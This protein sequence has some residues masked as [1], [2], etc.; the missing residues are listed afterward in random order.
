LRMAEEDLRG[1]QEQ[2]KAISLPEQTAAAIEAAAKVIG[3]MQTLEVQKDVMLATMKPTNPK[4]LQLQAQIEA[5]QKQL[6]RMAFGSDETRPGSTGEESNSQ[7]YVPFSEVPEVGLE[8][9]RLMRELKIQEVIFELL[10]QQ[11]EQA[12]LQE[13][14]DT[15]TVKILDSAVPPIKKSRPNRRMLVLLAGLFS[16]VFSILLA[17]FSEYVRKLR[18]DAQT[19]ATAEG[20]LGA[21]KHDL[22]NIK[23]IFRFS[24]N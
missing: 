20:I 22:Q 3:E 1:F 11:Y 2:Y 15:P 6:D 4:V 14:K 16:L 18:T 19:S 17:F 24:R 12:K 13:A 23:K 9:A 8:L 10:T 7:F 21:L 5:M